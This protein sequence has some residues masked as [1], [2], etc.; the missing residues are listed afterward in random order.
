MKRPGLTL[1]E[2][3]VA[4][5][6]TGTLLVSSLLAFARH[7]RQLALADRQIEA[8]RI[9]DELVRQLAARR[10]GIPVGVTGAV[11]GK[12]TWRWQTLPIGTTALATLQMQVI[13]LRIVEVPGKPVELVSVDLFQ[14]GPVLQRR[15]GK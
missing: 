14:P 9:A 8:A 3:V 4:L 1:L 5:L 6:L 11:P 15:P 12:P 7:R 10:G 2:V 13:R